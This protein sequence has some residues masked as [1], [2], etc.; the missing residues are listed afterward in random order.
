MGRGREDLQGKINASPACPLST[1]A[2]A[3][4]AKQV[5][6]DLSNH[7]QFFFLMNSMR[8]LYKGPNHK[9]SPL[10]PSELRFSTFQDQTQGD[11]CRS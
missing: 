7:I 2:L 3:P 9:H 6:G 10:C 5:G 8:F 4:E 11:L 1:R